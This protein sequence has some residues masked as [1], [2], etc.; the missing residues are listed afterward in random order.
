MILEVERSKKSKGLAP[1]SGE[2][3]GAGYPRVSMAS[4]ALRTKLLLQWP[5]GPLIHKWIQISNEEK[6]RRSLEP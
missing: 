4:I 3:R 1:A 5:S 6:D 2:S